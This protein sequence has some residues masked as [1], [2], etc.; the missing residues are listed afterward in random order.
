MLRT[1]IDIVEY[2]QRTPK[3]IPEFGVECSSFA[4]LCEHLE[5]E[6]QL[7]VGG[8]EVSVETIKSSFVNTFFLGCH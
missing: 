4:V 7:I 5:G 6:E 3:I 2:W 8:L 1:G